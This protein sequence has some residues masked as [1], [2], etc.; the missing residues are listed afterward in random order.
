MQA[1]EGKRTFPL[2]STPGKLT[3]MQSAFLRCKA[4]KRALSYA[5]EYLSIPGAMWLVHDSARRIVY[6][7]SDRQLE[8]I[9]Y[10]LLYRYELTQEEAQEIIDI[11]RPR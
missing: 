3:R 1:G 6:D 9:L 11:L 7:M 5:N 8:A 10:R 4:I 2:L